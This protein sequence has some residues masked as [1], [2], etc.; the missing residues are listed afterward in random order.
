MGQMKQ[1]FTE[2]QEASRLFRVNQPIPL[3]RDELVT[4]SR[5]VPAL[6]EPRKRGIEPLEKHTSFTG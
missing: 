5:T 2:L 6:L 3:A 4:V 1:L